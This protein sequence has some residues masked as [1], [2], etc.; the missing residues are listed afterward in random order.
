MESL[1]IAIFAWESLYGIKVGGL[2]PH[3]SE[4]SE[5]L[6]KKGHEVHVFTRTGEY[7][8]YDMVN[9]V[10]YQR[11][12]NDRKDGIIR[13]MDALCDAFVDRFKAVERLFGRFDVLHGHDW[14]PVPALTRLKKE[15]VTS[16]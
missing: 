2:A 3:V 5:A 12:R 7:G 1:R 14:H 15:T 13:Q 10:H 11:V 9:G 6:A 8:P 16:S 4:L